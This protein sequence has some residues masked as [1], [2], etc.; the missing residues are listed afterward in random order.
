MDFI[1]KCLKPKSLDTKFLGG[2]DCFADRTIKLP[3]GI[4]TPTVSDIIKR[5]RKQFVYDENYPTYV[6]FKLYDHDSRKEL[7][8][9]L[10]ISSTQEV[11]LGAAFK[12]TEWDIARFS[13]SIER[14]WLK[15][16]GSTRTDWV[17]LLHFNTEQRVEGLVVMFCGNGKAEIDTLCKSC[18]AIVGA[19][20]DLMYLA[21][22]SAY[23]AYGCNNFK[24]TA[25]AIDDVICGKVVTAN[26]LFNYYGKF[27]FTKIEDKDREY[28]MV[29]MIDEEQNPIE[30]EAR[31][32]GGS[33]RK[34]QNKSMGSK[35]VS[36]EK[37]I[38]NG[39]SYV[40]RTTYDGKKYIMRKNS[41]NQ[42]SKQYVKL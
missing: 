26:Q 22:I 6:P 29:M 10:R 24:L 1:R 36:K 25:A 19:G 15:N 9:T 12:A 17:V 37:H 39:K 31:K 11:C 30:P 42:I 20:M 38:V 7:V 28:D 23:F 32:G 8:D 2:M 27:G 21:L 5:H 35:K 4:K 3:N 14:D 13:G 33:S 18:E 16:D 41:N 40:V 34:K